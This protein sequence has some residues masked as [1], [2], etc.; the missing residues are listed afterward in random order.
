MG[1]KGFKEPQIIPFEKFKDKL[2]KEEKFAI[3]FLQQLNSQGTLYKVKYGFIDYLFIDRNENKFV[4]ELK[5]VLLRDKFY[6]AFSELIAGEKLFQT[7]KKIILCEK[8]YVTNPSR[9]YF[10][11]TFVKYLTLFDIEVIELNK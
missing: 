11:L 5:E 8:N 4:I 10:I 1:K 3:N 2:P 7:N 9:K 6:Q